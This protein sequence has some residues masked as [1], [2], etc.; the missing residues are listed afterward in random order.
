[1]L[2][3]KR[4]VEKRIL[5]DCYFFTKILCTFPGRAEKL[6]DVSVFCRQI[7]KNLKKIFIYLANIR[8]KEW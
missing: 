2:S 4:S 6:L 8:R 3:R 1:M 7:E 5:V